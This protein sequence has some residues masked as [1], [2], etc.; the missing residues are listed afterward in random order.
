MLVAC[1]G[2]GPSPWFSARSLRH[3]LTT[4]EVG[5][6]LEARPQARPIRHCNTTMILL[7]YRHGL[8][9]SELVAVRGDIL[10]VS[11]GELSRR[12]YPAGSDIYALRCLVTLPLCCPRS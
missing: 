7:A 1:Q 3:L 11:R 4:K 5:R 12:P 9:P 10:N 2:S 6:A 8:R